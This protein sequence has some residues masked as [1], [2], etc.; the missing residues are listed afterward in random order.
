MANDYFKIGHFHA[1]YWSFGL[2]YGHFGGEFMLILALIYRLLWLP[3]EC[4]FHGLFMTTTSGSSRSENSCK[5]KDITVIK[6]IL[7]LTG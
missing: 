3:Y 1:K 4:S 2:Y 5:F 6:S 7:L